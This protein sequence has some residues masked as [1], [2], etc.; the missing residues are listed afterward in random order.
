MDDQSM[1]V[2]GTEVPGSNRARHKANLMTGASVP[3]HE[4]SPPASAA[5]GT[6]VPSDEANH[7]RAVLFDGLCTQE[8]L[9]AAFGYKRRTVYVLMEQGLPYIKVGQR[10]YFDLEAVREWIRSQQI[11]RTP[12]GRG[13]P[14]KA[15]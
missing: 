15:A 11:D 2:Q 14:K 9:A 5:P 12:R 13:R 6:K 8:Q 10:R 3:A 4:A 1:A 7:R